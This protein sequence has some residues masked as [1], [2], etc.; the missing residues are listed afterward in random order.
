MKLSAVFF[1]RDGT[2]IVDKHYLSDPQGVELI[3]GAGKALALLKKQTIQTFLV[4]NQSGIGRGYF[5][6][7]DWLRCQNRL[8]NLLKPY[9]AVFDDVRFCP[10]NPEQRC[11]CRKPY[12][13]MWK[14]LAETYGLDSENCA[15]VGDKLEDLLFGVYAEMAVSVLV[16][17]GK[18][19]QSIGGIWGKD[20]D[21][22]RQGSFMPLP[23]AY[24]ALQ[25]WG[26]AQGFPDTKLE[27]RTRIFVASDISDAVNGL[28]SLQ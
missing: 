12:T 3:P 8:Q 6:E 21:E 11:C 16:L 14:S 2:V 4:S 13:G 5:T 27:N 17:T 19:N 18:G 26:S 25:A 7:Q 23:N 24:S 20:F 1:D 15:M 10:H 9:D 28:L 22:I